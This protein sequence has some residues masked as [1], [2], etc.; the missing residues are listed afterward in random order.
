MRA[1]AGDEI[2]IHGDGSQ[3]RAWCFVDDVVEALLA[4]LEREEAVGQVFN[5]GNPRSVVT[6]F[7]LASRIKRLADSDSEIVF[8]PLH[9]TDVEMRI[10]NVDKAL[11]LLGWEPRV[12]LD[13]GLARTIA[14]YR[15][16]QP[17]QS[18]APS[19]VKLAV[20]PRRSC[21]RGR[22]GSGGTAGRRRCGSRSTGRCSART[23]TASTTR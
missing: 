5:V 21:R 14:W 22:P 11:K 6:V 13:D 7:D 12:D 2:V 10:P 16:R 9:Y 17:V 15:E 18:L 1:L 3:I 8:K 20:W 23:A 4:M 19:R